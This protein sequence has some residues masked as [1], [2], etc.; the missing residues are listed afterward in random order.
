[1]DLAAPSKVVYANNVFTGATT[2]GV[3]R[4]G[5]ATDVTHGHDALWGNAS[6]YAGSA[7]DGPGTVKADCLLDTTGPA[8][9]LGPASPCRG[10]GD[11]TQAPPLDFYGVARGAKVDLGA[12]QSL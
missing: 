5:S 3:E 10:V 2:Y 1:M 12:V 7:T 9:A 4:N 6:N 11:P 8:P